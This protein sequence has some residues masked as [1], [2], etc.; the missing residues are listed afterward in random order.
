MKPTLKNGLFFGL[1][2][3]VTSALLYAPKA[4]KELREELKDK[5]NNVPYHFFNLLESIVDLTASVLD[6]SKEA[7]QEQREKLSKAVNSG[8]V[9]A[10]EKTDE[11]KRFA[12]V[13]NG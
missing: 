5:L 7:F 11:L 8:I 2:V 9:A 10:K 6:F 12:T 3:G 1:V 13:K 4:G